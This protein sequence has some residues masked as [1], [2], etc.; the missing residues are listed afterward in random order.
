MRPSLENIELIEKYLSNEMSAQ[1]KTNFENSLQNNSE[2]QQQL[3]I[4]KDILQTIERMA[5]K[6]EIR[7]IAQ[8][9]GGNSWGKWALGGAIIAIITIIALTFSKG[10][11]AINTN[12]PTNESIPKEVKGDPTPKAEITPAPKSFT[13]AYCKSEGP[14]FIDS[15]SNEKKAVDS[16][17]SFNGLKTW[18]EPEVQK[19]EINT[20]KGATIE[21]KEGTLIIVPKNAF[22][23]ANNNVVNSVVTLEVVEALTLEDMVLYNLTTTSNGKALESGG[24]LY[25][26]AVGQNGDVKI[27]PA[28]P[29]YIEVPTN[30]KK[31]DMAL[32]E[33][34]VQND[35]KLNWE[36]PKALKKFLVNIPFKDLDFL[37]Q[38][39]ADKVA[40]Y[41]PKAKKEFVDSLYYNIGIS[42]REVFKS[43]RAYLAS[44][45]RGKDTSAFGGIDLSIRI[46]SANKKTKTTIDTI[47]PTCGINPL[48]IKALKNSPNNISFCNTQEFADRVKQLHKLKNGEEMFSVYLQNANKD[49][50][51][52]DSVVA[53]ALSDNNKTI[54][55]NFAAQ[56]LGNIKDAELYQNQLSKYYTEKRK[57]YEEEQQKLLA[58]YAKEQYKLAQDAEK[59]RLRDSITMAK[60]AQYQQKLSP[61]TTASYAFTYAGEGWMNIDAYRHICENGSVDVQMITSNA[62]GVQE[63]YQ[64]LN[65]INTLTPLSAKSANNYLAPFPLKSSDYASQ[66]KNTFCF[67]MSKHGQEYRFAMQK[68]NP[69]Q[70]A[71]LTLNLVPMEIEQIKA[72]LRSLHVSN[73]LEKRMN[74]LTEQE[75]WK[76]AHPMANYY[77][78]N[79]TKLEP[80]P[81]Q[82]K[83]FK[84]NKM[85]EELMAIAFNCTA[86]ATEVEEFVPTSKK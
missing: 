61:A 65:T 23:D 47:K 55:Q 66:M 80:T 62:A 82:L 11:E 76:N 27:N 18:M 60:L 1:E 24:M 35:G 46:G 81:E 44:K 9:S 2:L 37:P 12:A 53:A 40:Q 79:R 4:Q 13:P 33:G 28:R 43:D 69:Y 36:N 39:F 34:K 26:K 17:Y 52:S 16:L 7:K 64:W 58:R 20:Q 15:K 68:F 49:L 3:Q 50:C 48:S 41:H 38:G 21:G 5:I 25:I 67:A 74:T 86:A 77:S 56:K 14:I 30:N 75:E 45:K 70:Q 54:F 78:A 83:A 32:F 71:Q 29:L 19:F 10:E 84:E 22:V 8:Q 31:E 42:Q 73:D 6:K 57:K 51:Y 72:T 63:V 85:H 59:I